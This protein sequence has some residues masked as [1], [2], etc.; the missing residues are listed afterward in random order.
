MRVLSQTV[1]AILMASFFLSLAH[2]VP[3]P[4]EAMMGGTAPDQD[5]PCVVAL[6]SESL[7]NVGAFF[8][9]SG[10]ET[11]L[12]VLKVPVA[13][14]PMLIVQSKN[15]V[16]GSAPAGRT[17]TRY[18]LQDASSTCRDFTLNF[19]PHV[20]SSIASPH[21]GGPDA[22][23]SIHAV[24]N[25]RG[26]DGEWPK[27]DLIAEISSGSTAATPKRIRLFPALRFQLGAISIDPHCADDLAEMSRNAC[28]AI[29]NT[30]YGD[31]PS[32]KETCIDGLTGVDIP[33][34]KYGKKLPSYA[35]RGI[36]ECITREK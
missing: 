36:E 12:L 9:R 28:S 15:P 31:D 10:S 20:R 18:V 13:P 33:A 5:E 29:F 14:G 30:P 24:I 16:A 19:R 27:P 25:Y 22:K 8:G 4:E 17:I 1:R 34:V 23:V 21:I 32:M 35:L 6:L 7:L 2:A 26:S 11:Y 3:P